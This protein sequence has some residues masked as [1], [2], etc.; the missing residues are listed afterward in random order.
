MDITNLIYLSSYVAL[1]TSK[2]H[3]FEDWI[4]PRVTCTFCFMIIFD[5]DNKF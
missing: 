2:C 3:P 4:T 5:N 1:N